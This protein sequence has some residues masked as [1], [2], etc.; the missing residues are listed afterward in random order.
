MLSPSQGYNREKGGT[1]LKVWS[2]LGLPQ[3]VCWMIVVLVW[4]QSMIIPLR[5]CGSHRGGERYKDV[6]PAL[7]AQGLVGVFT[8]PGSWV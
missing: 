4:A 3:V 5:D 2:V 8:W 6:V 1:S 7:R